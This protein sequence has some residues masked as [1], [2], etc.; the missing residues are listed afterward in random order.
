MEIKASGAY[1]LWLVRM[2]QQVEARRT[3]FSKYGQAYRQYIKST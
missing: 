2:L 1:P 3:R